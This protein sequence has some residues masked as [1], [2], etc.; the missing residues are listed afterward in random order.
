M[1]ELKK[2]PF[3]GCA[4]NAWDVHTW[5]NGEDYRLRKY[6]SCLGCGVKTKPYPT[7]EEAAEV[8]NRRAP[9]ERT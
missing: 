2:C 1:V 7:E 3:C 8:W 4:A 9:E 5:K 6:V